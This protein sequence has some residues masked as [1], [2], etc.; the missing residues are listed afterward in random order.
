[1]EF[2]F[3]APALLGLLCGIFEFSGILFAQ[4]LL[5]G[6]A[7][8]ASRYGITGAE[9]A[10]VSREAMILQII[11]DNSYGVIDVNDIVM[12]TLVYETFSDVGQPEP[13]TDANGNDAFDE[14]EEYDDING[15]GAWDDD[16][17][18]AGLGGPGDVVVY[19][20]RY[21]WAIMIPLFRPIFGDTVALDANVAVR[22][23]PFAG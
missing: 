3:I 6:G 21:D 14:G 22:N 1:M 7:R 10:E 12:D 9:T 13:F 19:R 16:M 11:E 17:G 15:N 8:Q 18:S 20:L 2:A 5:E 4:T 23:E